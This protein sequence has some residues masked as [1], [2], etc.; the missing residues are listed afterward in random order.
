MAA[1]TCENGG[2]RQEGHV[3][4]LGSTYY[5]SLESAIEAADG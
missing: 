5:C 3:A 2:T 1:T 4:Y